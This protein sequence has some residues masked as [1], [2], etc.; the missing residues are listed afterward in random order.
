MR[1]S[2]TPA[3]TVV[4]SVEMS[5]LN[6]ELL[7]QGDHVTRK[8]QFNDGRELSAKLAY[9]V[10]GLLLTAGL[11]Y[12]LFRPTGLIWL[13]RT[14]G[15]DSWS[16][17]L[18]GEVSDT[19]SV[20][21]PVKLNWDFVDLLVSPKSS[22]QSSDSDDVRIEVLNPSRQSISVRCGRRNADDTGVDEETLIHEIT[23]DATIFVYEGSLTE[24][25]SKWIPIHVQR[26]DGGGHLDFQ[27][28]IE[29]KAGSYNQDTIPFTVEAKWWSYGL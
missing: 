17:V 26:A 23:T 4:P 25:S 16:K 9:A 22:L 11:L 6:D 27:L 3:C 18:P 2:L 19:G 10:I 13:I 14:G 28:R 12:L 24:L 1:A 5:A 8:S 15:W 21:Y 20:L 29:G 7:R